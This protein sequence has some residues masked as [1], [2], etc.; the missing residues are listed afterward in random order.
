MIVKR[1]VRSHKLR[2]DCRVDLQNVRN[3]VGG[4]EDVVRDLAR[5]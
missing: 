4:Q 2:R 5:D 3:H 1:T